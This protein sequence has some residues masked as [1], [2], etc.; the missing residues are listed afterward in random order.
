M[1]RENIITPLKA[2]RMN[3]LDCSGYKAIEVKNCVILDCPLYQ[4][5]FGKNPKRKGIG[6]NKKL[7]NK[8]ELL[9]NSKKKD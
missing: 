1:K 2:I 8:K 3:C 4:Y 9:Q 7:G 6:G 5:R